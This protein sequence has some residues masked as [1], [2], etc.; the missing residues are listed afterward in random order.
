M[1]YSEFVNSSAAG[2]ELKEQ[3]TGGDMIIMRIPKN[4]KEVG[5]A[6]TNL[7]GIS[8]SAFIRMCTIEELVNN[9]AQFADLSTREDIKSQLSMELTVLLYKNGY[10][11]QWDEEVFEKVLEQAENMKKNNAVK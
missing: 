2:T 8:F 1:K 3:L 9:K 11:P 7:R 6:A 4:F 10:P 5:A